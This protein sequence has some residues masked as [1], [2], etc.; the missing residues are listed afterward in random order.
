MHPFFTYSLRCECESNR[1]EFPILT[2]ETDPN[3]VDFWR[4]S[5]VPIVRHADH[6]GAIRLLRL[7]PVPE[8]KMHKVRWVLS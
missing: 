3:L 5:W 6:D 2:Y 8:K 4:G 7:G 1:G